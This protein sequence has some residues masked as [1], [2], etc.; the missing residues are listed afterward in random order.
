MSAWEIR[1][2]VGLSWPSQIGKPDGHG[3]LGGVVSGVA[4]VFAS[5]AVA[6]N[7]SAGA[8]VQVAD[9]QGEPERP[10]GTIQRTGTLHHEA[11]W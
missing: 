9:G 10:G 4:A 8:Q 5:F 6:A 1:V 3:L 7:V 11:P 2:M